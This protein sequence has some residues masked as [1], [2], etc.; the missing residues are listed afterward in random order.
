MSDAQ[1]R[2]DLRPQ[3]RSRG[4]FFNRLFCPLLGS[5]VN[6]DQ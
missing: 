4:T 3:M 1:P 2:S 6:K 5:S